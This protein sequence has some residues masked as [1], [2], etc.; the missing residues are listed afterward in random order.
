MCM[1]ISVSAYA[2]ARYYLRV[3][4]NVMILINIFQPN[5][6]GHAANIEAST[7]GYFVFLRTFVIRYLP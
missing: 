7:G 1:V 4:D 5:I 2:F 3:R 6:N